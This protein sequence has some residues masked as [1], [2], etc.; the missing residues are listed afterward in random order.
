M[1]RDQF[2][3]NP[4]V[5]YLNHGA[6]GACPRP[7]FDSYQHWQMEMERQPAE[8]LGRRVEDLLK[9]ARASLAKYLNTDAENLVYVSNA[10]MGLNTVAR[11]LALRPGDEV[12]TTDHEYGALHLM[13][14]FV[15]SKSGA[16]YVCRSIPLPVSS[17]EE[18]VESFW[19]AVTPRTRVI[20]IS[21]I[22]SPTALI[23]PIEEIC[24]RAREAR[25]LTIIDGAHAVGQIPL[26]LT[27][28]D[29]DFYSGNL[30]KW[31]CSPKGSAFLYARP[32]RQKM[33]EPL[34][35]SWGWL[36][37][38]TFVSQNQWQGTRDVAA[39]LAVPAAIDFQATNHWEEVRARCHALASETRQRIADLT[40]LS[41]VS[42]DDWYMQ[43]VS[44]PL[45]TL[46][47]AE[48]KRRLYDEHRVEAPIVT[49]NGRHFIRIS[50]QGYNTR[51]DTDRLVS[52]LE[53][54]LP[55]VTL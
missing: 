4:E 14:K 33:I 46:E 8:F 25:I 55:L 48:L 21:H 39:F 16:R 6:F 24:R 31:L 2:M 7:V 13:W 9:F 47:P 38:G 35:I 40:G 18:F 50:I 10:T 30:H 15:C 22:T 34:V 23:F 43:M 53:Q 41:P 19:E 54:L 11:S 17:A 26:N 20:F 28:L 12:L 1:L 3:L 37:N 27:A 52:A 42:P 49:W 32:D 45:P 36:E 44:A 51:E 5:A 29:P